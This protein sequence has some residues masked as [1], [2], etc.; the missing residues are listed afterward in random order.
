MSNA[1]DVIQRVI[2]QRRAKGDLLAGII[3]SVFVRADGVLTRGANSAREGV[4]KGRRRGCKAR[5]RTDGIDLLVQQ[6]QFDTFGVQ[7]VVRG[8]GA[9]CGNR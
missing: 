7:N 1:V 8:K 4:I 9:S 5:V 2:G 3:L 6:C